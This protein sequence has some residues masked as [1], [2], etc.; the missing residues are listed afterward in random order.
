L[1]SGAER[2]PSGTTV[3]APL[4]ITVKKLFSENIEIPTTVEAY[5]ARSVRARQKS[6]LLHARMHEED[7]FFSFSETGDST[8][9][10]C[11]YSEE[12]SIY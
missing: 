9:S 1:F 2:Q 3:L 10:E 12:G 8:S 11:G 5:T 7:D 6:Q 4:L